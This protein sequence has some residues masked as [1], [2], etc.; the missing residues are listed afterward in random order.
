LSNF[1][2]PVGVESMIRE[3]S[4]MLVDDHTLVRRG[5]ASLL[6]AEGRYEVVAEASDGEEALRLLEETPVDTVILDL[7]MPRMNGLEAVRRI[8]KRFPRIK[9]LILS[10]YSDEQ[11]INQSL[12]DGARGYI[13]KHAMDEELFQALDTIHNG[14]QYISKSIDL[15]HVE[16]RALD[17]P[18]LTV[19]EREILQL[20]VDGYTTI[21][22][23]DILDISPHTATRHRANLMQKLGAHS[24]VELLRNAAQRGL[25][26]LPKNLLDH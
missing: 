25:I 11:F 1:A 22:A 9:V 19:R 12:R 23:A 8:T 5:L 2:D 16:E 26:I 24:Q 15:G 10:M 4:V 18:E 6:Q 7:S 17:Q 20:I 14:E 21:E 13:L 3:R